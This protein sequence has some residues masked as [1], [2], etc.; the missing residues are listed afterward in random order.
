M[1]DLISILG[2][3]A[4]G[5]AGNLAADIPLCRTAGTGR[6]TTLSLPSDRRND[7]QVSCPLP[8]G[9]RPNL[10][11]EMSLDTWYRYRCDEDGVAEVRGSAP[12]PKVKVLVAG[13]LEELPPRCPIQD[14]GAWGLLTI[15]EDEESCR[16][17]CGI[18][19]GGP[20]ITRVKD[21][22]PGVWYAF[23]CTPKGPIAPGRI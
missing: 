11:T 16:V 1:A 19:G 14:K 3:L 2:G 20:W 17:V 22:K 4:L 23:H 6:E 18:A 13:R 7:C 5:I 21:V 8:G 10:I 9:Q 12:R 15:Q